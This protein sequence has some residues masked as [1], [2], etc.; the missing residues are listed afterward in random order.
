MPSRAAG[1]WDNQ[2]WALYF[3]DNCRFTSRLTLNLGLRWD[4]I[5]H[6]YEENNNMSNFYP[7]RY[8]PANAAILN[9]GNQTISAS[10]PGLGPSPNPMLGGQQFY[11]NGIAICNVGGIPNGCVNDSWRNFGPR[12]GF[13]YDLSGKGKTVIRGGYGIMYERIQ[14]NDVYNNAGT[15][16][17]SAS[18][19]F[20]NVVFRSQDHPRPAP[21]PATIPVNNITGMDNN[22]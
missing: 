19:N 6:T 14:G 12:L 1:H 17:F 21:R 22:Y 18:V 2:S 9:P 10:S 8:D 7:N 5:P 3:Q 20:N 13:A 15:P 4:G 16:P 11:P